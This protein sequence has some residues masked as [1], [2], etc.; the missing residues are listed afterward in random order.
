MG[1]LLVGISLVN[2]YLVPT[3]QL[4]HSSDRGEFDIPSMKTLFVNK[5][6]KFPSKEPKG[7][8]GDPSRFHLNLFLRD[9][10]IF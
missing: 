5:R 4:D 9:L 2:D 10:L 6:I 3:V 8:R 7:V 1:G